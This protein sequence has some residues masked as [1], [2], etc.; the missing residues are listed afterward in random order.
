[1]SRISTWDVVRALSSADNG[2]EAAAALGVSRNY[3]PRHLR[4][5]AQQLGLPP[6]YESQ[7][8]RR[9]Y[10]RLSE[11]GEQFAAALAILRQT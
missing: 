3:I 11:T 1:M 8:G 9:G 5:V 7:A 10:I 6:L 4:S 2:A